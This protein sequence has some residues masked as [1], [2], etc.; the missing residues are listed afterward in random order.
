MGTLEVPLSLAVSK[1]LS[2]YLPKIKKNSTH[3]FLLSN[4]DGSKMSKGALSKLLIRL[5]KSIL[6]SNVGVRLMRVLKLS[7]P[8]NSKLVEA[9]SA[10][11][12]ELGHSLRTAR[13]YL[14]KD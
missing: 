1:V 12:K 5:T 11:N 10:L 6:G 7:S 4:R 13:T 3:N 2:T 14:R 8:A 9:S